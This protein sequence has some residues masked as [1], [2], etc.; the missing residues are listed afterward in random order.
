MI[1]ELADIEGTSRRFDFELSPETLDLED[2][3]LTLKGDVHVTGEIEKT[4][5]EVVVTGTITGEGEIDCSRCLQPVKQE[6]NIEF[7]TNY[8]SPEHFAAD[9]ENEVSVADLETDV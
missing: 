5:A 1:V 6:L 9:K 4:A 2:P 8:V 7:R 3:D